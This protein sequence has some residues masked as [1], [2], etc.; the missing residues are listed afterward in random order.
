MAVGVAVGV[1]GS[2]GV[3]QTPPAVEATTTT[4]APKTPTSMASGRDSLTRP[5]SESELNVGKVPPAPPALPA[6]PSFSQFPLPLPPFST[7]SG[8]KVEF[9]DAVNVRV[10]RG[11]VGQNY[12]LPST[13]TSGTSSSGGGNSRPGHRKS[14]LALALTPEDEPMDVYQTL[15]LKWRV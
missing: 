15:D 9:D 6:P 2:L 14:S 13:G 8:V 11:V 7:S 5:A 12:A 1:G 10:H 4:A 3:R